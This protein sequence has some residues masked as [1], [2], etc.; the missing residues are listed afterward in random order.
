[1]RERAELMGGHLEVRSRIGSGT[2]VDLSVPA[3][4][5][6]SILVVDIVTGV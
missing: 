1:M 3:S 5:A 4:A 2:E 6:M